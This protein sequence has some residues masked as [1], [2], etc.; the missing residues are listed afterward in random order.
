MMMRE[1]MIQIAIRII[2][3]RHTGGYLRQKL[4]LYF[5]FYIKTKKTPSLKVCRDYET[6]C[7]VTK[8]V[9]RTFK[10]KLSIYLRSNDVIPIFFLLH[11]DKTLPIH[12][13]T[14]AIDTKAVGSG[15]RC[16]HHSRNVMHA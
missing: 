6:V 1:N 8:E 11:T 16:T 9:I 2:C 3:Y 13:R 4:H 7:A 14:T 10:I 5:D 15:S 12:A